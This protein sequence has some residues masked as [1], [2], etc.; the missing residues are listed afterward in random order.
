MTWTWAR[1]QAR[2]RAHA[3]SARTSVAGCP[4]AAAIAAGP[5]KLLA[6]AAGARAGRVEASGD[7]RTWRPLMVTL[8]AQAR[9]RHGDTIVRKASQQPS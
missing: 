8:K 5:Q 4:A 3:R 2:A 9:P 7:P 1:A 6:S